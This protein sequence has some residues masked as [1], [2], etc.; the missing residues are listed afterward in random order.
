MFDFDEVPSE[1]SALG[2]Q[3]VAA[4]GFYGSNDNYKDCDLG[5][6]FFNALERLQKENDTL[7]PSNFQLEWL[8]ASMTASKGSPFSYSHGANIARS[9]IHLLVWV[10]E[11]Q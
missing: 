1:V 11:L 6:I 8:R 9:K 5:L 7:S 2:T 10:A 3:V 4:L